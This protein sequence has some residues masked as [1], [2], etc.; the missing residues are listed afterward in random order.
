MVVWWWAVRIPMGR[1]RLQFSE[2]FVRKPRIAA[3]FFFQSGSQVACGLCLWVCGLLLV[4]RV[5]C[6]GWLFGLCLVAVWAV[7]GG[8]VGCALWLFGLCLSAVHIASE[9]RLYRFLWLPGLYSVVAQAAFCGSPG[10]IIP[11]VAVCSWNMRE[12]PCRIVCCD[13]GSPLLCCRPRLLRSCRQSSV[14]AGFCQF[15]KCPLA[16]RDYR[17]LPSNTTPGNPCRTP[18]GPSRVPT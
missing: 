6:I 4:G 17:K 2:E 1:K 3:C 18:C 13:R 7:P 8:C 9:G 14:V 11:A 10:C 16:L 12:S 5:D 15:T